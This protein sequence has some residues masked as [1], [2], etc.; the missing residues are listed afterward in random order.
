M[1]GAPVDLAA[2]RGKLLV[3][4]GGDSGSETSSHTGRGS[5]SSATFLG[6]RDS[7]AM[8]MYYV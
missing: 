5:G 8:Q 3:Q 7:L 6:P 4:H 2:F 1:D